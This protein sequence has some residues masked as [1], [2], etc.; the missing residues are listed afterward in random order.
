MVALRKQN[1]PL[2]HGNHPY[3]HLG[4]IEVYVSARRT[5]QAA[6]PERL[7]LFQRRAAP[8]AVLSHGKTP[9]ETAEQSCRGADVLG[10]GPGCSAP[11][12]FALFLTELRL[13]YE[14]DP[15]KP[16]QIPTGFFFTPALLGE[17]GEALAVPELRVVFE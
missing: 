15:L 6:A 16:L 3:R 4:V 11:N 17:F 9:T 13:S 7:P 2:A 12:T 1:P 14:D 8:H 5:H 10:A